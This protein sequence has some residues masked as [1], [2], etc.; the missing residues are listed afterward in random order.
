MILVQPN[1][2]ASDFN[3]FARNLFFFHDL[4]MLTDIYR[5]FATNCKSRKHS[6]RI[7]I[8]FKLVHMFAIHYIKHRQTHR[9]HLLT[10][11]LITSEGSLQITSFIKMANITP[12]VFIIHSSPATRNAFAV[13]SVFSLA[14]LLCKQKLVKCSHDST[15]SD[16][17]HSLSCKQTEILRKLEAL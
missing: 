11:S 2:Q 1:K 16:H 13:H 17:H 7:Y 15:V 9:R 10:R 3:I 4:T 14:I 6:F 5:S 12:Q 8:S